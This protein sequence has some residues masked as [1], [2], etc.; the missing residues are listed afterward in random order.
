MTVPLYKRIE[1]YLLGDFLYD[2]SLSRSRLN[3]INLDWI[4]YKQ[5]LP[6]ADQDAIEKIARLFSKSRKKPLDIAT[7]SQL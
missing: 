1:T 4:W 2:R 6:T 7:L 5:S 3:Q